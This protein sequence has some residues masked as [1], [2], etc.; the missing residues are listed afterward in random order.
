VIKGAEKIEAYVFEEGL[1]RFCTVSF[2]CFYFDLEQLQ[3][4]RCSKYEK[5]VYAL[6][7]LQFE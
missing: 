3:K 4:A 6:N 1:A 5:P 7:E 2:R